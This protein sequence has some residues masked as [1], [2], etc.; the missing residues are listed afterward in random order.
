M[1]APPVSPKHARRSRVRGRAALTAAACFASA[2]L[3]AQEPV[4]L[5]DAKAKDL[6][7]AARIAI[8]GG[9]GGIA[10]LRGFRFTGRSKF[11]DLNGDLLAASVEIRVQLPDRYL[12]IDSGSFGRRQVGYAGGTSL[13]RIEGPTGKV[14]PDPRPA[15]MALQADRSELARLLAAVAM[16]F[17][18]EVPVKLQ[19]RDTQ[20]EMPG[21]P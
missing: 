5:R 13:D 11:A 12:R 16:Y 18:E 7:S 14:T 8:Y 2:V 10:R 9:P 21:L 6:F 15:G 1:S 19:T 20:I 3:A 17:S 4:L